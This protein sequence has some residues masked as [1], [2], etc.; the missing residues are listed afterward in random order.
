MS[1]HF[2]HQCSEPG[3]LER[4]REKFCPAH[5]GANNTVARNRSARDHDR[6]TGDK[7]WK[8]YSCAAWVRFRLSFMTCNPICQRVI[9]GKQCTATA[10]ATI[11]HHIVSP[12]VN[13]QDRYSYNNVKAVC[14]KH[15]PVSSGE[16]IESLNCLDEIYVPTRI[17][18]FKF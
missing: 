15:H 5:R 10:T 4:V 14:E 16:P 17:P 7:I 2:F 18:T 11:C 13:P 12:R 1:Q 3:C 8:L 6:K 9:D